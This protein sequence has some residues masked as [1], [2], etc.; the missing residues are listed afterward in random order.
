MEAGVSDSLV[1]ILERLESLAAYRGPWRPLRAEAARLGER[2]RE[3][4]ARE[5][6]LDDLLAVALVGGSG[7]G[8]STL[9]NAIAGDRLAPTSEFRPCTS[10]PTVYHPPGARLTPSTREWSRVSGSA[11]DNLVIIDTPDSDTVVR[12]HRET[13]QRV[14]AE[15]DLIL[16]CG[17]REKYLDEATWSLLRPLQ[18]ERTMVCVETKA[19]DDAA[20]VREHW[21]ERLD[22]Q[23]FCVEGYFRVNALRT[24]DRKLAGRDPAPDE[25]DW[26]RL[27]AFLRDELTRERVQR[28]KRSNA[29]GLLTKTV[30]GLHDCI[31]PIS[32]LTE[33]RERLDRASAEMAR[34]A[35]DTVRARLF[36]EPHLWVF[37]LGR[38]TAL[39]AK[40]VVGTLYRW[41]ETLRGLPARVVRYLPGLRG[42]GPELDAAALLSDGESSSGNL[43][44]G[45]DTLRRTYESAR[46]E[47]RLAFARAGFELPPDDD[48]Y[49]RFRDSLS[50]RVGDVLRGPARDRL[51]ARA[52]LLTSWPVALLADAGPLAFVVYSGYRIVANYFRDVTLPA[53]FLLHSGAVLAIIIAVELAAM[54]FAVR[55]LAWSARRAAVNDLRGALA[56]A[57]RPAEAGPAAFSAEYE[58]CRE[59]LERA[60]EIQSLEAAVLDSP[61]RAS[62]V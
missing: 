54:S 31:G 29:L 62:S 39:R 14:L 25:F 2:V 28:I 12:E 3:L 18:G 21:L 45:G 44:P 48:G 11:L 40:G 22:A 13:V 55:A 5:T 49:A 50:E 8:K 34:A 53:E 19:E 56:G 51:K 9:L 33:L 38:E 41:F 42:G 60:H 1:S 15:C 52:R 36:A 10:T 47:L 35:F 43:D 26:P 20:P 37:A 7:V 4:R 59:A 30:R 27:T 61:E 17:S 6:R 32:E 16:I 24:L 57:A 23:G 58:A 46:S